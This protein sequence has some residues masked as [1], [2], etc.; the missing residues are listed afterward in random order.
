[1]FGAKRKPEESA[2]D[3]T[4]TTQFYLDI[5]D[6][7]FV[8]EDAIR[9]AAAQSVVCICCAADQHEALKKEPLGLLLSLE[10]LLDRVLEPMA[11]PG[12]RLTL[13]LLMMDACTGKVCSLQRVGSLCG[14][15][16]LCSS[17]SRFVNGPLGASCGG[18]NGSSLLLTVSDST[19]PAA[20]A[21]NDGARRGLR[22]LKDGKD[23]LGN[24]KW[25]YTKT[26]AVRVAKFASR[27][28]RTIN[29]ELISH[30]AEN[31]LC[32]TAGVCAYDGHLRCSL[33]ALWQWVW[34]R[35]CHQLLKAQ[36]WHAM[37]GS[38]FY[39]SMGLNH[40]MKTTTEE[41]EAALAEDQALAPLSRVVEAEIDR[42][43]WRG[44]MAHAAYT[45][46][47]AAN[48]DKINLTEVGQPLPVVEKDAAWKLGGWVASTAQQRRNQGADGGSAVTKIRLV[49]KN[50]TAGE[51]S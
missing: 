48:K 42:Q 13:A 50:S 34:P 25:T 39:D 12:L 38:S 47:K 32:E 49:V 29:G 35:Q 41:K 33:L 15:N 11:S 1:V 30:S 28:W 37:E 19:Y 22:L 8:R 17:G 9:A 7:R 40:V 4:A 16:R 46:F 27:L 23:K 24:E 45:A 43:K 5:Y 6:D 14:Q 20:N 10:F 44:D 36:T 26:A 2:L 3:R 31:S 18:D 51:K 21:V